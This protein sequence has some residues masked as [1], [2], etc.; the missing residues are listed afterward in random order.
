LPQKINCKYKRGV[1]LVHEEM[2]LLLQ[3][4]IILA[5]LQLLDLALHHGVVANTDK[6]NFYLIH[7]P[8]PGGKTKVT[9]A[10]N[11]SN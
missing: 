1:A 10:S 2:N 8:G 6:E 11:M 7:H 4:L 5:L 9:P 3:R